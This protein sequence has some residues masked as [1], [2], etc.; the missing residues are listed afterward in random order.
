[1]SKK[2]FAHILSI[3]FENDHD[4]VCL[5]NRGKKRIYKMFDEVC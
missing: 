5:K 3:C 2:D 1:M 4:W